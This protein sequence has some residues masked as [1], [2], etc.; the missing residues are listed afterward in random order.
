MK[1]YAA[2]GNPNAKPVTLPPTPNKFHITEPAQGKATDL[3]VLLMVLVGA[4]ITPDLFGV[5]SN[6]S[7]IAVGRFLL[8]VLLG[9]LVLKGNNTARWFMVAFSGLSA[10]LLLLAAFGGALLLSPVAIIALV[11][12]LVPLVIAVALIVPPLSHHFE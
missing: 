8:S 12:G 9:Y 11:F 6:P 5:F 3:G 2:N 4:Y 10:G 7:P 1:P